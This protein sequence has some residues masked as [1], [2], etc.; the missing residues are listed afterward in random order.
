MQE[1]MLNSAI[2]TKR[3]TLRKIKDSDAEAMFEY[4]SDKETCKYLKW[5]PHTEHTQTVAFV[6]K[7]LA[8]YENPSDVLLGIDLNGKL[9]GVV[10]LY[11][12]TEDEAEISCI[13]NRA[14]AGQGHMFDAYSSVFTYLKEHTAISHV[15]HYCDVENVASNKLVQKFNI[16][17]SAYT[18]EDTI[19]G[20]KVLLRK[21]I[22][23]V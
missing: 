22:V 11:N 16:V 1:K 9:I 14:Y 23:K 6:Q 21:Y 10:R 5:G 20:N 7:V 18:K 2:K 13:V 3:T 15:I 19:K 17:D 8:N 12:I 4:T